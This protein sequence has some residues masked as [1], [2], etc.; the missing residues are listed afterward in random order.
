MFGSPSTY[1]VL[2]GTCSLAIAQKGEVGLR[3]GKHLSLMTRPP[4]S[5]ND[6]FDSEPSGQIAGLPISILKQVQPSTSLN[7]A[8]Q[9]VGQAAELSNG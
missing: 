4:R 7:G 9:W 2:T 5:E 1:L 6:R 8:H 3:N